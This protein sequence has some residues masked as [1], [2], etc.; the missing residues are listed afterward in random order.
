MG[1]FKKSDPVRPEPRYTR[2]LP[3]RKA[4]DEAVVTVQRQQ[5]ALGVRVL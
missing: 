3:A 1:W 5:L 4:R 2:R